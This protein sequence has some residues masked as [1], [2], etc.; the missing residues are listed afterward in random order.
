[1][2][3][4]ENLIINSGFYIGFL[5]SV[6]FQTF[7]HGFSSQ[8]VKYQIINSQLILSQA[9]DLSELVLTYSE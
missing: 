2:K 8:F 6:I 4:Q 5:F 7:C 3:D 9:S 1:M